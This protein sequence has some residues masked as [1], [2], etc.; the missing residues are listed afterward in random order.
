MF[1]R[2]DMPIAQQMVQV[3]HAAFEAGQNSN[4]YTLPVSVIIFQ[5]HNV[6]ELKKELSRLRSLNIDCVEFFEPYNDIGMTAFATLPV[7]E[8]DRILFK[9][10]ILWGRNF[11]ETN[12]HLHEY[13]KI[14]KKHYQRLRSKS[15]KHIEGEIK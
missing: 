12:T 2:T 14:E 8:E 5:V 6:E 11:I 4:K 15:K 3:S 10:Y 1:V 13:L 9:D 7:F